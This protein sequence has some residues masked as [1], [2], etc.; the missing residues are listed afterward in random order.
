MSK[1]IWQ[2]LPLNMHNKRHNDVALQCCNLS[3]GV[4]LKQKIFE[5]SRTHSFY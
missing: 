1:Q 4:S 2:K 3:I 5:F